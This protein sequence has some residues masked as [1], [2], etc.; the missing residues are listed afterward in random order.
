MKKT[1]ALIAV[2]AAGITLASAAPVLSLHGA[3]GNGFF[4]TSFANDELNKNQKTWGENWDFAFGA[5]LNFSLGGNFGI[6]PEVN[7]AINNAGYTYNTESTLSFN[8]M[9]LDIPLLLTF[10]VNKW[11]FLVG[12]YV[13]FPL[14]QLTTTAKANANSD[15]STSTADIANAP[16]TVWGLTIGAGYEERIGIGRLVIGA[17][18]SFDFTPIQIKNG[19]GV[20]D[21]TRRALYLD[22]SYKLA[23]DF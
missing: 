9:S 22:V 15:P 3:A 4:G 20:I 1:M 17:R 6:Q 10:R 18:Y 19:L 7:L 14:T 5:G 11:N 2:L 21:F 13:S 16:F 12:P 23:L 8:Y